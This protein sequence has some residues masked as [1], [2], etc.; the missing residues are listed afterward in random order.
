MAEAV[1]VAT[2][3]RGKSSSLNIDNAVRCPT[4]SVSAAAKSNGCADAG[5]FGIGYWIA[6]A[7]G[8]A[9]E[10]G[11]PAAGGASA[12]GGVSSTAA[13]SG[14]GSRRHS[15]RPTTSTQTATA[16]PTA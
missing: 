5:G 11:G 1:E 13:G 3:R 6:G 14:A 16:P 8:P 4:R 7:V 12:T 15:R 9:A 2:R 10:A